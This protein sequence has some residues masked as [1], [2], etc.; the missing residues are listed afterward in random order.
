MTS[1][2]LDMNIY[3]RPFDDQNQMRI[4]LETL[5]ITMIFALIENGTLS[6]RWSFVLD[7]ENARDPIAERREFVQYVARCCEQVVEPDE[8]ILELARQLTAVHQVRARDALHMACAQQAGCDYLITSDDRLVTQGS[9]LRE[10]GVLTL[11]VLNPLD[12]IK[13]T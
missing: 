1:L 13:E 4:Q 12:F 6:A 11:Q 3:K 10:Q 5:A 8:S 7:Y 9:R 2:Y